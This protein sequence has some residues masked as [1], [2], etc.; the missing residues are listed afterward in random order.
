MILNLCCCLKASTSLSLPVLMHS[1]GPGGVCADLFIAPLQSSPAMSAS[2]AF[3]VKS[4][5]VFYASLFACVKASG[6]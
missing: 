2:N 5:G 1:R 4:L 3:K 6:G